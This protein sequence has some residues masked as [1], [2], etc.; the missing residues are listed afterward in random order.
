MVYSLMLI[1]KSFLMYY[2]ILKNTDAYSNIE[3]L[4]VTR[5]IYIS[6]ILYTM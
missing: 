5:L 3:S 6:I 4:W 1:L 2:G